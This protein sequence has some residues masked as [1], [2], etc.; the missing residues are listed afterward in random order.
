M[1]NKIFCFSALSVFQISENLYG[2]VLILIEM[3]N[4][5]IC[6]FQISENFYGGFLVLIEKRGLV[7]QTICS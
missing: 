3:F 6:I 4:T 5:I 2:G 7:V 1:F